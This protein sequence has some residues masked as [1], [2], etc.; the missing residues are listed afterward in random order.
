MSISYNSN[1]AKQEKNPQVFQGFTYDTETNGGC[2]NK[3][4]ELSKQILAVSNDVE[5]LGNQYTVLQGKYNMFTDFNEQMNSNKTSLRNS[6]DSIKKGYDE[7]TKNLQTQVTALQANDA[8]LMSDLEGINTLISNGKDQ[9]KSISD[10]R[11]KNDANSNKNSDSS[12]NPSGKSDEEKSKIADDVIAGKYGT[13]DERKEAL[14]KAGYDPDEVQK[15]V[16]NKLNGGNTTPSESKD[17][18]SGTSGQEGATQ[19][20]SEQSQPAQTE[21]PEAPKVAETKPEAGF[22]MPNSTQM[23][24]ILQIISVEG[25][26]KNP[27]E[28][29]NIASTMINRARD[30]QWKSYGGNDVYKQATFPSQYVSVGPT[31]HADVTPEVRQAVMDL[32]NNAN[33]GG[34]TAHNYESFRANYM[35]SYGGTILQPDGNRYK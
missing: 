13:G 30:P 1:E 6:I 7:I 4:E 15:I 32:F 9:D 28:A 31:D 14:K 23:E 8:S 25:G 34:S 18:S 26:A 16:N 11:T 12:T 10:A 29:V 27:A 5:E 33:N 21:R 24:E 17:S 20:T 22:V 35:D 2:I 19:P 3:F